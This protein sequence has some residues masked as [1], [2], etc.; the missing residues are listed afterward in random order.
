MVCECVCVCACVCLMGEGQVQHRSGSH[1]VKGTSNM[2]ENKSL[3]NKHMHHRK[4]F[5]SSQ[6]P[7]VLHANYCSYTPYTQSGVWVCRGYIQ[8]YT[9]V[10]RRTQGS[11]VTQT[12]PDISKERSLHLGSTPLRLSRFDESSLCHFVR[13]IDRYVFF[14][15]HCASVNTLLVLDRRKEKEW[16][17]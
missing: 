13:F 5:V 4:G 11:L 16:G 2:A 8:N 7:I 12:N 9:Y 10:R 14:I 3:V 15:Q 6:Q 17:S 1:Q